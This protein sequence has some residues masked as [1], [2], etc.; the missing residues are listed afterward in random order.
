LVTVFEVLKEDDVNR[1]SM[2]AHVA[3]DPVGRGVE[4]RRDNNELVLAGKRL[5]RIVIKALAEGV[6]ERLTAM[7]VCVDLG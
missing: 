7:L 3:N 6:L 2:F 1:H 4:A 5:R